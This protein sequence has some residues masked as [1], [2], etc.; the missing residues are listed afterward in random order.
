MTTSACERSPKRFVVWPV[1]AAV[2][3][4]L[5][6]A[7]V[8]PAAARDRAA[9]M[10]ELMEVLRIDR[11]VAVMRQEGLA[12]AESVAVAMLPDADPQAWRRKMLR[13]HDED[14]MQ[15]LARDGIAQALEDADLA[16]ML[17]FYRS[18]AGR[19]SVALE[20]AAR[21]A[22]L[23]P[24]ALEAARASA[25]KAPAQRKAAIRRVIAAGDL[26]GRNVAASLNADLMFWRGVT[27]AG[28]AGPE[29]GED[30]LTDAVTATLAET[31]RATEDWVTAYLTLACGP[32]TDVQME[33]YVQFY[34]TPAGRALNAALFDGFNDMYDQL[35]YLL[36]RATGRW[37]TSVPL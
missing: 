22:F 14:R 1:L 10:A 7:L 24:G 21:R 3:A 26:I 23:D 8:G 32:L 30:D 16:P 36:G 12:H 37:M 17:A 5:L 15:R 2:L 31:R 28:G 11:M 6:L 35:A 20:L 13:L 25:R 18:D 27:D 19:R 29:G 9:R 33:A 34:E 4:S